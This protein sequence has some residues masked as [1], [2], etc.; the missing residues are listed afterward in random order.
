MSQVTRNALCRI[1]FAIG[2]VSC[3]AMAASAGAIENAP[4]K[5]GE[6]ATDFTLKDLEGEEKSLSKFLKSGPVVVVVLR[7]FPGYQCPICS[8]QVS[9]LMG[10]AEK[11]KSKSTNVVLIYPGSIKDLTNKGKEFLKGSKLPE[12]IHLLIDSD[13]Q[14][15]NKWNLRWDAPNETAYPSTFVLSPDGKVLYAKVSKSHGGRA[16]IDEI[17]KAVGSIQK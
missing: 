10:S 11:F 14:F 4:P 1:C 6:T 13:Y 15:T 17:L 16:E 9:K 12:G 7:G 3:F 5:V 8:Q 2:F